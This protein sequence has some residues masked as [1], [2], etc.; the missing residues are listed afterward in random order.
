MT[1]APKL[2]VTDTVF[3]M[4]GDIAPLARCSS[5]LNDT[6]RGSWSTMPTASACSGRKAAARSRKPRCAPSASVYVGTLGKAAGVSGAFVIAHETVIEWFVQRARPYIFTTASA[7]AVAH[8]VS[9][10]LR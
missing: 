7:P 6:A 9:A 2:I 1:A 5:S 10:S 3:S 4:D 8:A